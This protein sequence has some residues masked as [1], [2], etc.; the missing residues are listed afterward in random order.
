MEAKGK[1]HLA[2]YTTSTLTQN[3]QSAQNGIVTVLVEAILL[4][5]RSLS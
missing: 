2:Y 1:D 5:V 4:L 3:R